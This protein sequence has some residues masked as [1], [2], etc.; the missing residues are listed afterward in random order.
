MRTPIPIAS[1][2]LAFALAPPVMVSVP[3]SAQSGLVEQTCNWNQASH[4][5]DKGAAFMRQHSWPNA[6]WAF[7]AAWDSQAKCASVK[8][9]T[10]WDYWLSLEFSAAAFN[11]RAYALSLKMLS[12]ADSFASAAK[13]YAIATKQLADYNAYQV[14]EQRIRS[15]TVATESQPRV[16]TVPRPYYYAPPPSYYSGSAPSGAGCDEDSI[17]TVG[18]DGAIL[19]MLSGTVYRVADYDTVTSSLWLATEDVLICGSRIVN[20]DDEG[21]AVDGWRVR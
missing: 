11:E 14:L 17:E 12:T 5:A 7:Q 19:V 6:A 3:A 16:V 1:A 2:A 21:E 20:K 18:D 13:G 10:L 15:A 9:N 8:R 4:Y